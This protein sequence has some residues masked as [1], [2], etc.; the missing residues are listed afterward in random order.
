[1][2]ARLISQAKANLH[3]KGKRSDEKQAAMAKRKTEIAKLKTAT[4]FNKVMDEMIEANA[5]P[6]EKKMLVSAAK[7][8]GIA[9]DPEL[10]RFVAPEPKNKTADKEPF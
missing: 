1:M 5:A 7:K 4:E 8:A 3:A 10:K 2:L 9:L 6:A